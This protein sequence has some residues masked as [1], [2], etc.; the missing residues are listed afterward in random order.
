MISHKGSMPYTTQKARTQETNG[1]NTG[2][3]EVL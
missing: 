3:R 1:Q 2:G